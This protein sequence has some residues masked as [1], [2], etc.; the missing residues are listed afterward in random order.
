MPAA[1]AYGP[2]GVVVIIANQIIEGFAT[3]DFLTVSQ[4]EDE[5]TITFGSHGE[6]T[7][8]HRVIRHG[9]ITLT[10]HGG[11]SALSTLQALMD[12]QRETGRA[13]FSVLVQDRNA[14]DKIVESPACSIQKRPDMTF[15][16]DVGTVEWVFLATNLTF[17]YSGRIPLT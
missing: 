10:M 13:S 14:T 3:G 15:G 9:T 6:Q 8:N 7:L 17:R 1:N 2:E 16:D 11:S 12:A 5:S 4:D